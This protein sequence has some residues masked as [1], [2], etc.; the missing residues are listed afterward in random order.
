VAMTEGDFDVQVAP[1]RLTFLLRF[2]DKNEEAQFR[3]EW[4]YVHMARGFTKTA[5]LAITLSLLSGAISLARSNNTVPL[6]VTTLP[7]HVLVTAIA[8]R[9]WHVRG[10]HL[11]VLEGVG[12]A[13]LV[14]V[15]VQAIFFSPAR[16]I[17]LF[18]D[19]YGGGRSDTHEELLTTAFAIIFAAGLYTPLQL[20]NFVCVVFVTILSYIVG[21][22][23][24]PV[25]VS[26]DASSPM[27]NLLIF[28][29]IG[30]VAASVHRVRTER[31]AFHFQNEVRQR[32]REWQEGKKAQ[33]AT[34]LRV[35]KV[36]VATAARAKLIRVVMHDLRSPLLAIRNMADA[37]ADAEPSTT[38][39]EPSVQRSVSALQTCT[40]LMEGIVSDMLDFERIDSG[41][42][43]LVPQPFS[44]HRLV[45]DADLTYAPLA[46]R[47]GVKLRIDP[48]GDDLVD[49]RFVGDR[50]RLLQCL[51]NGLSNAIKFSRAGQTVT[52]QVESVNAKRHSMHETGST[53][54]KLEQ[55]VCRV[56]DEGAGMTPA[57]LAVV[58][59]GDAFAQVGKG[60]LQ[61]SGGTG[62]GLN[63]VRSILDLHN[64][65]KLHIS[66]QGHDKGTTFEMRLRLPSAPARDADASR[67]SRSKSLSVHAERLS[68]QQPLC[69]QERNSH[70]SS[71]LALPK[72]PKSPS[73]VAAD[74]E[75]QAAAPSAAEA[76]AAVTA[77]PSARS[78]VIKCLHVEDDLMLQMTLGARIFT[79]ADIEC[80]VADDG[81]AAVELVTEGLARGEKPFDLVL[82]DNQMPRCGGAE[83]TRQLRT[84]GFQGI[85]IGMT[86]DPVGSPDRA[87]FEASGLTE[88]V[89]KSIEGMDVIYDHLARLREERD[90]RT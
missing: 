51:G 82:M 41:R 87:D 48:L 88:C 16:M 42:M 40:A 17:R 89:D 33:L 24:A 11:S 52:V 68:Q 54:V 50:Q 90:M 10:L 2:A 85:I 27:V 63:I 80:Q 12:T 26:L 37:L 47:K 36:E 15:S 59:R 9:A 6:N 75:S 4:L 19:T 58:Q 21:E 61:G 35:S 69:Q 30:V 13:W 77:I 22:I 62:L 23:V 76:T 78:G 3:E 74:I 18:G 65:S 32:A 57:E 38:V 66:S 86:G 39:S 71:M 60:Q 64:K 70:V 34:Q 84:M 5:G 72:A 55:V 81:Q 43:V 79:A 28:L 73:D 45:E 20:P 25:P 44:I 53:D 29:T 83:A 56:I 7:F 31:G 14:L 8:A 49:A 1:P 46:M 67:R